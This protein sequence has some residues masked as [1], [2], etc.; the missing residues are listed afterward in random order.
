MLTIGV[1]PGTI[2]QGQD[3]NASSDKVLEK[4][5]DT[6]VLEVDPERIYLFGSL[7]RGEAKPG[8]DIDVLIVEND[9]TAA[10]ESRLRR[11]G[12]LY[13]ALAARDLGWSFDILLYSADEFSRWSGSLNHII[14][15]CLRE[16]RLLYARH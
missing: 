6:I 13:R 1:R 14:G 3:M 9:P 10:G 15:R 8:S 7:A 11:M 16:G 12:R 2:D 5:V 4:V